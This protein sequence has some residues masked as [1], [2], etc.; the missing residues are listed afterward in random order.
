M[1]GQCSIEALGETFANP[2]RQASANYGIGAD[3]RIGLFCDEGDRSWCS[4]NA[5]NDNRAIT[6]ECASDTTAPYA[7][8]DKVYNSL[9]ALC[10]DICKRNGI[11]KL[12]WLADKNLIGIT[13]KQNITVHRW[14]QA[15]E[16]PGDYIYNRLGQIAEDVNAKLSPKK[17]VSELAQEVIAG[18]WGVDPERTKKLTAAGYDAAAIQ[19]E[20][21]ILMG[22]KLLPPQSL[23]NLLNSLRRKPIWK[24]LKRSWLVNGE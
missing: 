20:V 23:R 2:Q 7:I 6:I 16:C 14:F 17:T 1:V 24:L 18:K 21:D 8:N 22:K 11:S 9:I 10:A 19:K 3:G 5:A 15:T 13:D 4:G 12:M